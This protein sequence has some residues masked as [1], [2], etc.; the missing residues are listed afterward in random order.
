MGFLGDFFDGLNPFNAISSVVTTGMN[1]DAN[2]SNINSTNDQNAANIAA[3]N[4]TNLRIANSANALSRENAQNAM[5]FSER[6]SNTSYQRGVADMQAAG[7]NPMLAAMKGG[8][9]SPTG[10][11]APVT[12]PT[13]QSATAIPR[14][15]HYNDIYHSAQQG[16]RVDREIQNMD[17]Q[18]RLLGEHVTH[19]KLKQELTKAQTG[20]EKERT[21]SE[22]QLTYLRAA[23]TAKS[24]YE[25]LRDDLYK[26]ELRS[27][28][29]SNYGSGTHAY[30]ASGLEKART[31]GQVHENRL[32]K[33]QADYTNDNPG[34][35]PRLHSLNQIT[36]S[37]NQLLHGIGSLLPFRTNS[38]TTYPDGSTIHHNS[39]TGRY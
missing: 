30:S 17:Q 3:T 28:I 33:D 11:M 12:T 6:M 22:Q 13:M 29:F 15:T 23:E 38:S 32:L 19:E 39:R 5:D 9:S 10:Q 7:I 25:A 14:T 36:T 26:E 37:A 34:L 18:N 20:T 31:T 2:R 1:N 35:N 27:R 21:G 8:A 16:A 4:D 24:T